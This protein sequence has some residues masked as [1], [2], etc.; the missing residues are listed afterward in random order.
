M[1]ISTKVHRALCIFAESAVMHVIIVEQLQNGPIFPGAV[2]LVGVLADQTSSILLYVAI[3]LLKAHL[4]VNFFIK[5]KLQL[6][7]YFILI[8]NQFGEPFSLNIYS[9]FKGKIPHTAFSLLS[10]WT[11]YALKTDVTTH[12]SIIFLQYVV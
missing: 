3:L 6:L 9:I 5:L 7:V 4:L 12:T 11:M 10:L 2:F 8:L 1:P